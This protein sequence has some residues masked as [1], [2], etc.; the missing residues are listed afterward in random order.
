V[1]TWLKWAFMRSW[2]K[3]LA[4]KHVLVMVQSNKQHTTHLQ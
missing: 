1:R 2:K 4:G 3:I